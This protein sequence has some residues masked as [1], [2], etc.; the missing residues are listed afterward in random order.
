MRRS[1]DSA[2][3]YD[4]H[5]RR[6]AYSLVDDTWYQ[7]IGT[8]M[9]ILFF[10]A[11]YNWTYIAQRESCTAAWSM[12]R[13]TAA[14]RLMRASFKSVLSLLSRACCVLCALFMRAGQKQIIILMPM[15]KQ[16]HGFC[17]AP[18]KRCQVGMAPRGYLPVFATLN[19]ESTRHG[20]RRWA[21][22]EP[23]VHTGPLRAPRPRAREK[24]RGRKRKKCRS[25]QK[26]HLIHSNIIYTYLVPGTY[27]TYSN[28]SSI[29]KRITL[30]YCHTRCSSC[31]YDPRAV[32]DAESSH[33][34]LLRG[35]LPPSLVSLE[36][37]APSRLESTVESRPRLFARQAT[38]TKTGVARTA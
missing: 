22:L 18:A 4:M 1:T 20:A 36:D 13:T 33:L 8:T 19:P 11:S 37:S 34:C 21:K 27:N 9:R 10:Q 29:N 2:R 15:K 35:T 17:M 14:R 24:T 30:Q 31:H 32:Q 12:V 28:Y 38:T 26:V 5:I 23:C 3:V 6:S 7:N 25:P 16:A